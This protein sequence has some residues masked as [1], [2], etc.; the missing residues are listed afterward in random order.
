MPSVLAIFHWFYSKADRQPGEIILAGSS[1]V[2]GIELYS[3]WPDSPYLLLASEKD[4]VQ[5]LITILPYPVRVRYFGQRSWALRGNLVNPH[6]RTIECHLQKP[7]RL[8][9]YVYIYRHLP[10]LLPSKAWWISNDGP[11]VDVLSQVESS[12]LHKWRYMS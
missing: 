12:S 7:S 6:F 11:K 2:R 3:T 1:F 5:P 4:H 9:T 10:L 8:G